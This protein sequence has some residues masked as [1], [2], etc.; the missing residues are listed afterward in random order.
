MM[1]LSTTIFLSCLLS[2]PV[3]L[4]TSTASI[5][6]LSASLDY[7]KPAKNHALTKDTPAPLISSKGQ[8]IWFKFNDEPLSDIVNYVANNKN[9]NVVFPGQGQDPTFFATKVTYQF[10][11]RISVDDAYEKML[12]LLKMT[13]YLFVPQGE[14]FYITKVDTN[15]NKQTYPLYVNT[16]PEDLPDTNQMIRYIYYFA[17]IQVPSSSGGGFGGGGSNALQTFLSDVLKTPTY[18]VEPTTNGIIFT[19]YARTIKSVMEIIK[20][21]DSHGFTDAIEILPLKYTD[22]TTIT[23]LFM[24][25]LI[26]SAGQGSGSSGGG[27]FGQQQPVAPQSA[28][29]TASYFAPTTK[30]VPEPRSNSLIIMGKSDAIKRVKE[31]TLKYIDIPLDSGDSVLHIYPLQYLNAANFA[32]ILTQIVA[33]Q[34]SGSSS[35]GSGN[36]GGSTGQSSGTTNPNAGKQ[37][38]TGVIVQ[39]EVTTPPASTAQPTSSGGTTQGTTPQAAQQGGNRLLIAAIREDWIRIKQLIA[40]LDRPQPQVAIEMLI[41]DFTLTGGLTLGS[42]IRNKQD[43]P[44][45]RLCTKLHFRPHST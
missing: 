43:V 11:E 45:R 6:D 37:Y 23:N 14:F 35:S 40:D 31:F 22:A 29:S 4:Y 21:I 24:T 17:N 9:M 7:R 36:F 3:S 28:P 12:S 44:T 26:A 33:A 38:F 32:P 39:A 10:P 42:Q 8:K 15:L 20:E 34:S 13:G 16:P 19:D 18:L 2:L 5:D 25:Q 30:I 1:K 41:V 27:G